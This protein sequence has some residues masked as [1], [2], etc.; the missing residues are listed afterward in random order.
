MIGLEDDGMWLIDS[1][2]LRHMTRECRNILSMTKRKLPQIFELGYHRN[3]EI[4]GIGKA[5]IEIESSNNIHLNN[6]LYVLGLTKNLVSISCLEDKGDMVVFLEEKVL[7]WSKGSSI[8]AVRVIWIHDGRLY[9]LVNKPNQVLV[10]DEIDPSEL[11]H[12]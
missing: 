1:V 2:A 4:K 3:Y 7:V 6:A 9:R 5:S 10:H 8:D 11:W 12:R